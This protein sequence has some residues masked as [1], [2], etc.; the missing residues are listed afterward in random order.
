MHSLVDPNWLHL[1]C[2][3]EL[4]VRSISP[5]CVHRH[6]SRSRYLLVKLWLSGNHY[7]LSVHSHFELLLSLWVSQPSALISKLVFLNVKR[8]TC[9]KS[10]VCQATMYIY[11]YM[12]IYT[13]CSLPLHVTVVPVTAVY[14]LDC[15]LYIYKY[16][17]VV[18]KVDD[19]CT[20]SMFNFA[21]Y[22]CCACTCTVHCVTD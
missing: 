6:P 19:L 3:V 8:L 14:L 10:I 2:L 12:Y 17:D 4:S 18:D 9:M 22:T 20:L 11:M 16:Y 13:T 1:T 5:P 21:C 7:Q 15:I